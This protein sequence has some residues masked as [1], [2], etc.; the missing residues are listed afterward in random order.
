MGFAV[1]IIIFVL[2]SAFA[3]YAAR[4]MRASDEDDRHDAGQAII[5]FARAFPNEAIRSLHMTDDGQAV[6]VRLHGNKA[7]FMRNMGSHFACM[8]ISGDSLRIRQLP[9][10][11]SFRADFNNAAKYSGEF[12]FATA[13]EAAEVTLWLLDSFIETDAKKEAEDGAP[14]TVP[15]T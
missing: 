8:L 6:F 5:D 7:G 15:T 12:R 4:M 9:D 10:N 13:E 11:R 1:W 3:F 14:E 2:L